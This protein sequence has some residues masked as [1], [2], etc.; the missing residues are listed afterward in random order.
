M[1][2]LVDERHSRFTSQ[3]RI[4]VRPAL[5]AMLK[6][7][8]FERGS[9]PHHYAIGRCQRCDSIVEP[10]LSKQW[11]VKTR[12][13]ADKVIAAVEAEQIRFVPEG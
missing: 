10:L 4:K 5:K 13:L 7:L 1:G 8:G 11:F 9:E 6:D 12:P 3:D 2:K